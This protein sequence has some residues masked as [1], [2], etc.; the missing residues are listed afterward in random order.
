M[1]CV[2]AEADIACNEEGREELTEFLD[3]EDD[4]PIRVICWCT[5]VVLH[6]ALIVGPESASNEK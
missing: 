3:S 2:F 4:R 6:V 1:V 5:F